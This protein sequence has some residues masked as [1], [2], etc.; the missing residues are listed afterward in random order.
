MGH[1]LPQLLSA[2]LLLV[3]CV[4]DDAVELGLFG[5][6]LDGDCRGLLWDDLSCDEIGDS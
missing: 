5:L 2:L 1:L 3:F 4:G 6:Q